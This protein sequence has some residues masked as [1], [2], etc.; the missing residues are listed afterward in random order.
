MKDT[1]AAP[2]NNGANTGKFLD[3]ATTADGQPRAT[4]ALRDD[5]FRGATD[6]RRP[7]AG[8]AAPKAVHA[9]AN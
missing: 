3:P 1:L 6:P 2:G 8:A 9:P 7:N 4:V 5:I